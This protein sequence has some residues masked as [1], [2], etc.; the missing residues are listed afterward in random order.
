MQSE[1]HKE[2]NILKVRKNILR[3]RGKIYLRERE[4]YR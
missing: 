4:L 2:K 1:L 3:I